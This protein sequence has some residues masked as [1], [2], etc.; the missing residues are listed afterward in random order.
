MKIRTFR[1][2]SKPVRRSLGVLAAPEVFTIPQRETDTQKEKDEIAEEEKREG[3]KSENR[4]ITAWDKR[5]KTREGIDRS[6][7]FAG[8]DN[9]VWKEDADIIEIDKRIE[10][11]I[12][13]IDGR[14]DVSY[15]S[16]E[17]KAWLPFSCIPGER[18]EKV[19]EST[20]SEIFID[21]EKGEVYKIVPLVTKD[22]TYKR[23][24]HTKIDHFIKE[25]LI[26]EIMNKS[27]YSAKIFKWHLVEGVYPASIL[28]ESK[29]WHRKNIK[30]AENVIPQKNNSSGLF[31]VIV[32]EY[33]GT[34]LEKL[35]WKS[36]THRDIEY[37]REGIQRCIED[38][39][40]LKVEHRDLHESNIL[41][42]RAEDGGYSVKAIDYSLSHA[43]VSPGEDTL[44]VDVLE[45]DRE[46]TLY[47]T[48][49][50]LYTDIDKELPWLFEGDDG[51]PHRS[52][53]HRMNKEYTGHNRWRSNGKSNDFWMEYL[54]QWI[55][56]QIRNRA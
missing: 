40:N 42:E 28:K 12:I 44:S 33:G 47:R 27:K 41:V 21:R 1:S 43:V 4:K 49:S 55:G 24:Q 23:V 25:C 51:Q 3:R 50:I 5:R 29:R 6:I 11:D 34:E 8:V 13:E 38:M 7:R 19:G 31:G 16:A 36:I 32:M 17:K 37:I 10:A 46:Y 54:M 56:A 35:D 14:M 2:R 15:V 26:M 52:V 53:Y 20:F 45:I 9:I 22:K 39:N 30:I 18:L 48:G